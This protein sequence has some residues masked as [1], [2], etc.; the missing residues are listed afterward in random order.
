MTEHN[1]SNARGCGILIIIA[2]IIYF[3]MW[4][5]LTYPK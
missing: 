4:M 2:G 1:K 3:L 5:L